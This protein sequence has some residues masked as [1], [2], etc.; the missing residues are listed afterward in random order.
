[1]KATTVTVLKGIAVVLLLAVLVWFLHNSL[2]TFI[3]FIRD[4]EAV[5]AYLDQLGVVGPL[6]LAALLGL[7]VL[8][9]SLPAEPLMIAGAYAY[10]LVNG[11]LLNWLVAV[12][13]TQAVFSLARYAGRPLVVRFVPAKLLDKWMQTADEKG[14]IIFLLA[15]VIPPIPSDIMTYV[16]GVSGIDGRRFFM[17]NLFGRIPMI[18]LLTLVG[19]NGLSITPAMMVGLTLFGVLSLILWWYFIVRKRP[20][21]LSSGPI[22]AS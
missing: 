15:F 9:P 8:I 7:Q 10:G 17:A 1:M 4:R 22:D 13:A 2:G 6:A 3:D 14:A 18:V 20:D 12:G 16:A 5:V 19:V 21:T 11:F